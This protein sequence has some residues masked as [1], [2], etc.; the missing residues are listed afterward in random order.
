MTPGRAEHLF[1]QL[2]SLAGIRAL[3]GQSEDAHFDCKEWP[4]K[5]EDA[6]KVFAKAACGLVNAEGGVLVIGMKARRMSKDQ[7][8]LVDSLAPVNDTSDVKSRVLD[9]VGQLVEPGIEG[10]QAVEINDP[11]GSKAGF[12]IVY[13]PGSEG[14]PRRSRKDSR[15]YLRIGSGT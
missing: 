1:N 10:I 14:L 9:L 13:I 2:Q 11:P 4:Q 3:I 6:Q 7:P 5:V 8:D 12:V 15:F